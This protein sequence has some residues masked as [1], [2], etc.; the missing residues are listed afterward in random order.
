[1]ELHSTLVGVLNGQKAEDQSKG[2]RGRY[3]HGNGTRRPREGDKGLVSG[4]LRR[5]RLAFCTA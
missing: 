5:K 1:M 3:F 4:L 2:G